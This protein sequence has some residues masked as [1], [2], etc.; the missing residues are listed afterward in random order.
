MNLKQKIDL[1]FIII[2]RTSTKMCRTM[3]NLQSTWIFF[4]KEEV[5]NHSLNDV[6]EK[7][8]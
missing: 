8:N 7:L 3:E 6:Y 5:K 2:L 1:T 4:L